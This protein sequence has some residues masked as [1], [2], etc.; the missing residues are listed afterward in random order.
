MTPAGIDP[1][2]P[3]TTAFR[4]EGPGPDVQVFRLSGKADY[5][6]LADQAKQLIVAAVK[7]EDRSGTITI[8]LVSTDR[9]GVTITPVE[10]IGCRGA[11][12]CRVGFDSV[13]LGRADILGGAQGLDGGAVPWQRVLD[14]SRLMAAAEAV[15]VARGAF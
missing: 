11:R 12:Y 14:L 3:S 4:T 10:K 7:D 15:G 2:Q 6:I 5:V 9:P 1:L 8:F 13:P